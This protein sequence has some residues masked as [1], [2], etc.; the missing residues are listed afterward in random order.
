MKQKMLI[1]F[2]NKMKKIQIIFYCLIALLFFVSAN[3]ASAADC[4]SD[5]K[6]S[7]TEITMCAGVGKSLVN[8]T[9]CPSGQ[10]CCA[11]SSSATTSDSAS[12]DSCGG[13]CVAADICSNMGGTHDGSGNC[14]DNSDIC[15]TVKSQI[16]PAVNPSGDNIPSSTQPAAT[17][18]AG[19]SGTFEFPNPIKASTM[20]EFLSNVLNALL[21]VVAFI[22]LIF[23]IIGAVMYMLSS[24][25]EQNIERAKK[26]IT[27]AVVGLAIAAAA[28]T[29]LKEIKNILGGASGTNADDIVNKAYTLK[30]IAINVLNFLLA[31]TGIIAIIGL[32]IG[33]IFYLTSYGN[34]DRMEKGK[35]ILIASIIGIIVAF[36]SLVIVRQVAKLIAAG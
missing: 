29:F 26:T 36:S 34:E 9:G 5:L 20:S 6:G 31:V 21:G 16:S 24:G 18:A 13:S 28:P 27:G 30:D 33:A 25:N 12:G 35:K 23:I 17:T 11:V 1:K 7:C 3:M 19:T 2:F 32:I 10:Y 4:L 15:C 14:S 22:S 8:A